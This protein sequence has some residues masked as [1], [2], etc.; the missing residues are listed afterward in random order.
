MNI[1]SPPTSHISYHN[2]TTIV[3]ILTNDIANTVNPKTNA[4]FDS[5]IKV[6]NKKAKQINEK[7]KQKNRINKIKKLPFKKI[8]IPKIIPP[9]TLTNENTKQIKK[10]VI[11]HETK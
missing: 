1:L 5:L 2:S 4:L 6:D 10:N 7:L 11:N 8:L 3:F 9:I